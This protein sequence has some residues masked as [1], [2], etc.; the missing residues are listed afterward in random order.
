MM[1]L[2]GI[3]MEQQVHNSFQRDQAPAEGIQKLVR[4]ARDSWETLHPQ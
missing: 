4:S 3:A 2:D 1:P